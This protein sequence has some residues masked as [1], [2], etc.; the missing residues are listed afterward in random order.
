MRL[1]TCPKSLYNSRSQLIAST[2]GLPSNPSPREIQA[3]CTRL[4]NHDHAATFLNSTPNSTQWHTK[5][6]QFAC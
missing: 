3:I 5:R 1:R 6:V 2:L 4:N